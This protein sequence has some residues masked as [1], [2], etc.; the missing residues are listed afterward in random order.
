MAIE[1][2]AGFGIGGAAQGEDGS[3]ALGRRAGL[4]HS[5]EVARAAGPTRTDPRS[6]RVPGSPAG[7]RTSVHARSRRA[8]ARASHWRGGPGRRSDRACCR[9]RAPSA[10]SGSRHLPAIARQDRDCG[11]RPPRTPPSC[12]CARLRPRAGDGAA[13]PGRPAS[14]GRTPPVRPRP[15]WRT[16]GRGGA[17]RCRCRLPPRAAAGCVP[18]GRRSSDDGSQPGRACAATA[19]AAASSASGALPSLRDTRLTQRNRSRSVPPPA[20]R[21]HG[22][23]QPLGTGRVEPLVQPMLQRRLRRHASLPA[24]P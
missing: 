1:E 9:R 10:P 21:R 18:P 23:A 13:D 15:R 3:G 2:P 11:A 24:F 8:C 4:Q 19:S 20:R 14:R 22:F 5:P 6:A 16:V 12:W 7:R 17:R